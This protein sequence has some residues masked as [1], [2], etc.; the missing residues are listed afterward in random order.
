MSLSNNKFHWKKSEKKKYYKNSRNDL[1]FAGILASLCSIYLLDFFAISIS[2]LLSLIFLNDA[3]ILPMKFVVFANL[4]IELNDLFPFDSILPPLSSPQFLPSFFC[5]YWCY[6]IVYFTAVQPFLAAPSK[7][8]I[9]IFFYPFGNDLQACLIKFQ[10]R[11]YRYRFS[12]VRMLAM[13]YH[14]G[15]YLYGI[16]M[17]LKRA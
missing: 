1:N 14:F 13:I 3:V 6:R 2:F 15:G 17:H 8:Y 16:L 12:F 11:C 9:C 10:M 5:D 4:T 7:D